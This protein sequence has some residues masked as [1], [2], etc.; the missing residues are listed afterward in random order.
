MPALKT[1]VTIGGL[2]LLA[3]ACNSTTASRLSP[4]G[5]S[6][7]STTPAA[8]VA[9]LFGDD[10]P[11]AAGIVERPGVQPSGDAIIRD[12]AAVAR[13]AALNSDWDAVE[14]LKVTGRGPI[15]AVSGSCPEKTLTVYSVPV[16]VTAATTFPL[17]STCS[18]LVAG[19]IITVTGVLFFNNG[20]TQVLAERVTLEGGVNTPVQGE[21][22]VTAISG[23]PSA[24]MVIRGVSLTVGPGAQ[25]KWKNGSTARCTDIQVGMHVKVVGEVTP[26]NVVFASTITLPSNPPS[27]G[28]TDGGG[29]GGGNEGPGGGTG[30]SGGGHSPS[31][32]RV[33]GSGVVSTVSGSCP[34][35]KIGVFGQ[36]VKTTSST[37]FTGGSCSSIRTGTRVEIDAVRSNGVITAT[38][39]HLA[40]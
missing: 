20:E 22:V 32:E 7:L 37:R 8:T 2:S 9:N 14:D 18:G 25:V 13:W 6:P 11:G 35:I 1:L 3:A 33:S 19:R 31:G 36:T 5:P 40:L 10:P 34:S 26:D 16:F 21:G 39:V 27:T 38:K 15:A 23:C 28:G 29:N 30:G 17:G 24:T 4:V 12:P